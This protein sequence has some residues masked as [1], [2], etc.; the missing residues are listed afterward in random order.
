MSFNTIVDWIH[1]G[2]IEENK[3]TRQEVENNGETT[4]HLQYIDATRDG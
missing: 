4:S 3:V 2:E 1:C